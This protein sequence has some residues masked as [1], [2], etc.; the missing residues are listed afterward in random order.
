[1]TLGTLLLATDVG[2]SD[3]GPVAAVAAVAA[4]AGTTSVLLGRRGLLL[5]AVVIELVLGVLIGPE[6]VG[7]EVTKL[8]LFMQTAGLALLFF[9][10]G[11]E[12]D[13]DRIAGSPLKLAL[14][15]WGFS[16]LLAYSIGGALAAV[17]VVLSL[18]YTGSALATTAIG[19]LIPIL[20]DSGQLKTRMGTNLL[21]AGAVGEFGPIILLTVLLAGGQPLTEAV[22]L[23]GFIVAAVAVALL[24][25]RSRRRSLPLFESTVESSSQIAVRWF[26]LLV[27]AL[28]LLASDL[29]IDLLLGGFAA[30]MITRR[31]VGKRE[32]PVLESKLTAIAFGVFIP[33]FFVVSGMRLD[34]SALMDSP[35]G[36]L[37]IPL[38]FVLFLV[39]RGVPALVVYRKVLDRSERLALA[40]FSSTQLPLV[41][42]ITTVALE[43]GHMRKRTAAALVAAAVL[44]TVTFP[45]SA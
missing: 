2:P 34:F 5:P 6:V 26:F 10:A 8:L 44:S 24:A 32:V 22:I 28:V 30:G 14:I 7:L 40:F 17:G 23:V 45:S 31:L 33:Y 38:F 11:Y 39:V 35:S 43:T 1:M 20:S 3:L 13:P 42:A 36:F 15:G 9:F 37:L 19:T 12:I 18:L 4:V 16:L 27:M 21:A 25:V 29:G 41:L